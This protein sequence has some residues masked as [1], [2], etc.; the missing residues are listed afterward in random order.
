MRVNGHENGGANE[1]EDHKGQHDVDRLVRLLRDPCRAE[2]DDDDVKAK[3]HG[4]KL[5]LKDSKA[6]AVDDDV[7]E[8]AEARRR[9][10]GGQRHHAVSPDLRIKESLLELIPLK[11]SVLH[12]GLVVADALD[13]FELL[14]LGKTLGAHRGVWHPEANPNAEDDGDD[15][16]G[17]EEPL[18]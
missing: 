3:H 11:L 16:V 18:P 6:E 10:G 2:K 1:G 12:A 5:R 13:H 9:E 7:C 8:C 15:A 14:L 4:E 17:K